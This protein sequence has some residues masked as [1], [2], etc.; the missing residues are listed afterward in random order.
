MRKWRRQCVCMTAS[1]ARV[2][3][4]LASTPVSCF[5]GYGYA[6]AGTQA[7]GHGGSSRASLVLDFLQVFRTG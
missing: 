2:E 6:I 4:D 3:D 1:T 5:T 7:L